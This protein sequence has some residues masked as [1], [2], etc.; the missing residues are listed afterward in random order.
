MDLLGT[1]LFAWAASLGA[2]TSSVRPGCSPLGGLGVF[3]TCDVP[4]G[5]VLLSCPLRLV[6]RASTAFADPV[7]GDPLRTLRA[8]LGEAVVDARVV[9]CVLLLH[10]R[11]QGAAGGFAHYVEAL[12]GDELVASLPSCWSDAELEARLSGTPLLDEARRDRRRRA[13][14]RGPRRAH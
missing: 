1:D 13:A 5:G 2:D 12:P 10:C 4:S 6:L 11:R 7:I 9:L 3:A 14:P 8:E